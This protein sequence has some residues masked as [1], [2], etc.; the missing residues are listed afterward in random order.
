MSEG[1]RA[2][3]ERCAVRGR[4]LVDQAWGIALERGSAGATALQHADVS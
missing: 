2:V 1:R 4:A 3:G